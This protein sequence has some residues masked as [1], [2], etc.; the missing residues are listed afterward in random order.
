MAIETVSLCDWC[1]VKL[2]EGD[3]VYC[4]VCVEELRTEIEELKEDV[5]TLEDKLSTL[6]NA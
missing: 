6:E 2:G 3:K 1:A 4:Q 5:R